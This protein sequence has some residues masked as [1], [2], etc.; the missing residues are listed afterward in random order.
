MRTA[1]QELIEKHADG[2]PIC[3][4]RDAYYSLTGTAWRGTEKIEKHPICAGGCQTN[5]IEAKEYIAK[6]ILGLA[7]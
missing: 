3:N 6:R 7:T 5:W 2:R 4:C 1:W